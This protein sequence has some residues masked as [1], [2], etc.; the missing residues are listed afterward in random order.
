MKGHMANKIGTGGSIERN[1]VQR[2]LT[3]LLND[4][5]WNQT[6]VAR[7]LIRHIKDWLK[8]QP[9]RTKRKGGLGKR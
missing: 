7:D 5:A 2:K 6:G 3:R 1:L 9:K 4:S 8:A